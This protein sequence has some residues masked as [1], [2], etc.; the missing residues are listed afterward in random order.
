M[1]ISMRIS[2]HLGWAA[3][4]PEHH[5]TRIII[6]LNKQ[7][8]HIKSVT[9]TI[10]HN[11]RFAVWQTLFDCQLIWQL[12]VCQCFAIWITS[13]RNFIWNFLAWLNDSK[14]FQYLIRKMQ[15]IYFTFIVRSYATW[16][17]V[18]AC[19]CMKSATA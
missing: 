2:V 10:I 17:C 19:V 7:K 16:I 12:M 13:I 18:C 9:Q 4:E 8:L 3:D 1:S 14:W 11:H 15:L 6:E 5:T